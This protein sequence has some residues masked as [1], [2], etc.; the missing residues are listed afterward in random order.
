MSE[1]KITKSEAEKTQ[2]EIN[3][4]KLIGG[5]MT[6][7]E[8]V[9]MSKQQLYEIAQKGYQLIQNWRLEEAKIIYKG[10]VA[11]DPY[12]S[13][14]HCQLAGIYF[15]Q[16]DYENAFR[17][18]DSSIRLNIANVDALAGRGELYLMQGK[19]KEGISDLRKAIENDPSGKK[20]SSMRA[21]GL[22][23]SMKDAMEENQEKAQA[24]SN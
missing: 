13:V 3:V 9:G 22:L 6:I 10:L 17:A 21:R 18:Y 24:T 7:S 4:E 12:D 11:A 2:E 8:F 19:Y 16:K 15:K 14:F 5:E 23:I 20:Q 1:E